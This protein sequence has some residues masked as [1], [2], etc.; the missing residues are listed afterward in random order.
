MKEEINVDWKAE[1]SGSA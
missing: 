1:W